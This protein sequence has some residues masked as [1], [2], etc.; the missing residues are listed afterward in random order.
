MRELYLRL[1]AQV[2]ALW[3]C[4]FGC[5]PDG[6]ADRIEP[7]VR[8]VSQSSGAGCCLTLGLA[9]QTLVV[10][11]EEGEDGFAAASQ[12]LLRG[13]SRIC[14]A[15]GMKSRIRISLAFGK[16]SRVYQL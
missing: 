15:L 7:T 16:V 8:R 10:M 1:L 14:D 13:F 12:L 4:E 2:L 11:L 3:P 6:I 9:T 5:V